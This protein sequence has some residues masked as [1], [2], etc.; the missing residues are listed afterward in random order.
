MNMEPWMCT[1]RGHPL[2]LVAEVVGSIPSIGPGAFHSDDDGD[3]LAVCFG[4]VVVMVMHLLHRFV[5][6]CQLLL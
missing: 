4:A 3:D 1:H 2:L 5:T 6:H